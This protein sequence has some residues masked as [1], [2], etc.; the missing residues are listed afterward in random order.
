M[1]GKKWKKEKFGL[2]SDLQV[3]AIFRMSKFAL[4]GSTLNEMTSLLIRSNRKGVNEGRSEGGGKE[5]EKS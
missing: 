2:T 4:I 3:E 5:E 1:E